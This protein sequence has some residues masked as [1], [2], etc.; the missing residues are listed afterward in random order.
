MGVLISPVTLMRTLAVAFFVLFLFFRVASCKRWLLCFCFVLCFAGGDVAWLRRVLRFEAV[1]GHPHQHRALDFFRGTLSCHVPREDPFTSACSTNFPAT[2]F[3]GYRLYLKFFVRV[4]FLV[5]CPL[6]S[7]ACGTKS[8]GLPLRLL[9]S[10]S[11]V[12]T[13]MLL[14]VVFFVPLFAKSGHLCL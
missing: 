12:E 3:Q 11:T 4:Y 14:A 6:D 2:N 10:L 13:R 9:K 8:K 5:H 7:S 1:R